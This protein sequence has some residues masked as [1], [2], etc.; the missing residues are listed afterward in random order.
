MAAQEFFGSTNVALPAS[1]NM[2]S[3]GTQHVPRGRQ[4][5]LDIIIDIEKRD[6]E[7]NIAAGK[8]ILRILPNI[9]DLS[10]HNQVHFG[11]L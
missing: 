1:G 2:F 6:W 10:D 11:G 3:R 4:K 8:P 5:P 9:F 7:Y